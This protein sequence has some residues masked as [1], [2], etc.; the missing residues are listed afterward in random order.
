VLVE[1]MTDNK[2][3]TVAEVRHLF[4]STTVRLRRMA[5]CPGCST[6]RACLSLSRASWMRMR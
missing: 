6:R 1:C 5:R 4:T 2:Q 3:R